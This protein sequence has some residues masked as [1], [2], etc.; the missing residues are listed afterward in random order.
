M[1]V[2]REPESGEQVRQSWKWGAVRWGADSELHPEWGEPSSGGAP[3][4]EA[5]E[6]SQGWLG[7]REPRLRHSHLPPSKIRATAPSRCHLFWSH[8]FSHRASTKLEPSC[9]TIHYSRDT[10]SFSSEETYVGRSAPACALLHKASSC[11]TDY[12]WPVT[13]EPASGALQSE[14]TSFFVDWMSPRMYPMAVLS[15]LPHCLLN[16]LFFPFQ[17]L[18]SYS[19]WFYSCPYYFTGMNL[20]ELHSLYP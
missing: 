9:A 10:W 16:Y 20:K 7:G 19:L 5:E 13:D 17:I 6:W 15:L 8:C 3:E 12:T 2:P 4:L 1:P 14:V 11:W 18:F